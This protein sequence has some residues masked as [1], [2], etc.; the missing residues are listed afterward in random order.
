MLEN[1]LNTQLCV[2]HSCNKIW[3]IFQLPEKSCDLIAR[4]LQCYVTMGKFQLNRITGSLEINVHVW[5][6]RV[7]VICISNT[8]IFSMFSYYLEVKDYLGCK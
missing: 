7:P 4:I 1:I 5:L 8:E 3:Y 6:Y 2:L